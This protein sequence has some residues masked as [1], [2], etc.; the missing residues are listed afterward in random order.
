MLW[1]DGE[2]H[3]YICIISIKGSIFAGMARSSAT[4]RARG[5]KHRREPLRTDRQPLWQPCTLPYALA[6]NNHTNNIPDNS[7]GQRITTAFPCREHQKANGR[8][9]TYVL[10]CRTNDEKLLCLKCLGNNTLE[11]SGGFQTTKLQKLLH[12]CECT[13]SDGTPYR[14]VRVLLFF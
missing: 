3:V 11:N 9:R 5:R 2:N 7:S 10:S 1:K 12:C 6:A 14:R 13:N 4:L 8:E